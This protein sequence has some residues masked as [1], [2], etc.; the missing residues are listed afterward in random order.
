[1]EKYQEF[2][3]QWFV[4]NSRLRVE[5]TSTGLFLAPVRPNY[6]HEK[7]PLILPANITLKKEY[8]A[9]GPYFWFSC[10]TPEQMYKLFSIGRFS[11]EGTDIGEMWQ[12]E[13]YERAQNGAYGRDI[14]SVNATCK[15]SG[16]TL[17]LH[18]EGNLSP[19]LPESPP[20]RLSESDKQPSSYQFDFALPIESVDEFMSE[21]K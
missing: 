12:F 6:Y 19:V 14:K 16:V 11:Q 3:K 9:T 18:L 21:A 15:N 8:K 17:E 4:F 1:M 2:T 7:S 13:G 5:A 10:L 20:I